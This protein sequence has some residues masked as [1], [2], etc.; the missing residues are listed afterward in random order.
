MLN[1][2]KPEVIL[3]FLDSFIVISV[4]FRWDRAGRAEAVHSHTR[5]NYLSL[6][7]ERQVQVQ[8]GIKKSPSPSGERLTF[9]CLMHEHWN[10]N[11]YRAAP[12]H[13]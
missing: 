4:G 5:A 13:L 9:Y 1:R 3:L 8:E 7:Q 11:L 12:F 10:S 6:P 2:S